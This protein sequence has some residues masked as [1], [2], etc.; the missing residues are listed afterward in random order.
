MDAVT[1]TKAEHEVFTN[2]WR[3]HIPYG[4]GTVEATRA[5]I[6]AAAQEIYKNHPALLQSAL[7]TL[8]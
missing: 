4:R 3:A 5:Q 7:R 8:E 1:V 6:R 2:A